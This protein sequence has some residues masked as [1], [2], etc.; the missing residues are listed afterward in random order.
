MQSLVTQNQEVEKREIWGFTWRAERIGIQEIEA[1]LE[2]GKEMGWDGD[3]WCQV[4]EDESLELKLPQLSLCEQQHPV[5]SKRT[6]RW[7]NEKAHLSFL[8]K[9][10]S[11]SIII[12]YVYQLQRGSVIH[13]SPLIALHWLWSKFWFCLNRKK[14]G[15][16]SGVINKGRAFM[17]RLDCFHARGVMCVRGPGSWCLLLL[18]LAAA[19]VVL[20]DSSGRCQGSL[21]REPVCSLQPA[22]TG[23]GD[24]PWP[25]SFSC[26]AQKQCRQKGW[27]HEL[28]VKLSG[29]EMGRGRFHL[30]FLTFCCFCESL[31]LCCMGRCFVFIHSHDVSTAVS[32]LSS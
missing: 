22:A 8:C 6:W 21:G 24:V 12:L 9:R 27:W 18:L 15:E 20:S 19:L 17:K 25:A 5:E 30:L 28:E 31:S 10:N 23:A 2:M 32:P 4:V 29:R 14:D 3:P 1:P 13:Q 16:G 11:I 26:S 7:E